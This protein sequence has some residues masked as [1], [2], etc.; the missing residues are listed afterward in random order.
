MLLGDIAAAG[1]LVDFAWLVRGDVRFEAPT[2][3]FFGEACGL[4]EPSSLAKRAASLTCSARMDPLSSSRFNFLVRGEGGSADSLP[5]AD[6]FED[7]EA[8]FGCSGC[9]I[10]PTAS[11]VALCVCVCVCVGER[12]D[13][14]YMCA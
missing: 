1:G 3:V 14:E 9:L 5:P 12:T 6:C 13:R 8:G 4:A 10:S 7:E 11:E 2:S